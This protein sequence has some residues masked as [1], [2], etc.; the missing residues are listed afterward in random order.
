MAVS[1]GTLFLKIYITYI[2]LMLS[3]HIYTQLDNKTHVFTYTK[4][5]NVYY[6]IGITS[7]HWRTGQIER[8]PPPM[9]I[10]RSAVDRAFGVSSTAYSWRHTFSCEK[11]PVV[12]TVSGKLKMHSMCWVYSHTAAHTQIKLKKWGVWNLKV[13]TFSI[14]QIS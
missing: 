11:H 9:R 10:L 13:P 8:N 1:S 12:A 5:K 7:I 4:T 3:Q 14:A 2:K 6:D